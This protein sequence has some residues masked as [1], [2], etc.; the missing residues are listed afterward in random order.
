MQVR[1]ICKYSRLRIRLFS[2][3]DPSPETEPLLKDNRKDYDRRYYLRHK[4]K[5]KEKQLQYYVRNRDRLVD[6]Q[7]DAQFRNKTKNYRREYRSRNE[8]KMREFQRLHY[9]QNRDK[10]KETQRQYRMQ[11]HEN[12]EHFFP[13]YSVIKSWKSPER[14]REFFESIA[15]QLLISHYTD[16]YRISRVQI[17]HLGGL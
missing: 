8:G 13:R 15:T 7:N 3:T 6:S 2:I 17:R 9:L 12:P 4:D 16:W 11:Q 1:E 14:V 10:R 5:K